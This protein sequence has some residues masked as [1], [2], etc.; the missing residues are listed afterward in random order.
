MRN[1]DAKNKDSEGTRYGAAFA[2]T[3]SNIIY[4]TFCWPP[5]LKRLD[6][7][8]QSGDNSGGHD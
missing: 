3:Y 7:K 5:A 4:V 1:T 6:A 2:V 8:R